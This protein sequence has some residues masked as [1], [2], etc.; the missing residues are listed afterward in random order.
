MPYYRPPL[1]DSFS[2]SQS[3]SNMHANTHVHQADGWVNGCS[4][5]RMKPSK[6]EIDLL[7]GGAAITAA[8][9]VQPADGSRPSVMAGTSRYAPRSDVLQRP[10][11][12]RP[13]CFSI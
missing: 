5:F 8:A 11:I 7:L 9:T 3:Y 13:S 2:S 1:R 12:L 4:S 6:L 10:T